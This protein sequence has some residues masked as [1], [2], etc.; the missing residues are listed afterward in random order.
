MQLHQLKFI[1]EGGG[2]CVCFSNLLHYVGMPVQTSP[3]STHKEG[4]TMCITESQVP[5]KELKFLHAERA[6]TE[7]GRPTIDD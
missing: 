4:N 2:R 1:S 7:V 6:K 3:G 5:P